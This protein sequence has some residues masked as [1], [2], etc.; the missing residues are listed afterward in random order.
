MDMSNPST[1][2][3]GKGITFLR[4][5]VG[6]QGDDCLIWPLSTDQD[7]YGRFGLNGDIGIKAHRWMCEQVR[8]PAPS[9]KHYAAHECGNGRGGCVNPKHLFWKTHAENTEDMIRH[10]TTRTGKGNSKHKLDREKAAYIRAAKGEKTIPELSRMF[11]IS[12]RQVTKIQQGIS[13]SSDRRQDRI[14]TREEIQHIRG[15][16]GKVPQTVLAKQYGV[17]HSIVWNIQHRKTFVH[18]PDPQATKD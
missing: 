18:V 14:F 15:A 7:G 10:G 9:Q 12:Y 3:N 8:G 11:G 4:A 16:R 2:G 13:W 17:T 1:K 6:H 5:H